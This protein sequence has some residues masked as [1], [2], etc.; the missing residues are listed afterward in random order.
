VDFTVSVAPRYTNGFLV[1][2]PENATSRETVYFHNVI[3]NRVYV[4][5]VNRKAPKYHA[6]NDFV[7]MNDVEEIFNFYSDASSPLFYVEKV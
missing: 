2:S 5:S 3:G 7:Q 6:V 1:L 4:R